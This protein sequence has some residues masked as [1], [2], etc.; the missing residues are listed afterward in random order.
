MEAKKYFNTIK[1]K[2]DSRN[3]I[4]Y[5]AA[6]FP[7]MTLDQI[8]SIYGS[9]TVVVAGR[10]EKIDLSFLDSR[11]KIDLSFLDEE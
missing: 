9:K 2:T 1:K 4:A 7:E 10:S 3:A 11:K 8:Q 5:V 6:K